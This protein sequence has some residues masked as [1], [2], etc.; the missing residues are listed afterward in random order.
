[1]HVSLQ[2]ENDWGQLMCLT[3]DTHMHTHT[4]VHVHVHAVDM[5]AATTGSGA[6]C[7]WVCRAGCLAV[8]MGRSS[9]PTEP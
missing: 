6:L 5:H 4:Q 3:M 8:L 9:N 1:M 2:A 7:F